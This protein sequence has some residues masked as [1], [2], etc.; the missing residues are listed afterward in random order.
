M[1]TIVTV[2]DNGGDVYVGAVV[3]A[4]DEEGRRNIARRF[5]AEYGTEDN[6]RYV[7]FRQVDIAT[8]PHLLAHLMNADDDGVTLNLFGS[9]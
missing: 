4:V 7:C 1:I 9:K 2:Y 3:G 8:R 5:D 6:G